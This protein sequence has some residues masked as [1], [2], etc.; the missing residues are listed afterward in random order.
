MKQIDALIYA[1]Q[2]IKENYREMALE[3]VAEHE[4]EIAELNRAQLRAG[5]RP[6]GSEITPAYAASTIA[7]KQRKG[8][9]FD[10]VTLKDKGDYHKGI[11]IDVFPDSFELIGTDSKTAKLRTKYGANIGLTEESKVLL[12]QNILAPNLVDKMRAALP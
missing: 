12:A 5:I 2:Q 1:L 6:D 11:E 3:V 9:P 8:Q 10:R 7:I 4:E